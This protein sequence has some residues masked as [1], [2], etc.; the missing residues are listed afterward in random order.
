[1]CLHVDRRAVLLEYVLDKIECE[2][3]QTFS[4]GNEHES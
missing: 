1:V 4:M 2:A 3:A